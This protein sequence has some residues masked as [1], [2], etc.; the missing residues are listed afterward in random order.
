[1]KTTKTAKHTEIQE[2]KQKVAVAFYRVSTDKQDSLRQIEDVQRY[3]QAYGIALDS[4]S[5]EFKEVISG[6]SKLEDRKELKAMLAY[7][8]ATRPDYVVC[9]ELSRLARS[10]DALTIIENWTSKGICFIT[11]KENIK[12]LDADGRTNPMT[13]LLLG[14]LSAINI[15]ELETIKYRTKSG[16]NKTVQSG[17]WCG[18]APFGYNT[19]GKESDCRLVVNDSEAPIVKWMFERYSEGWGTHKIG[20]TLNRKKKF[21]KKGVLWRPES[22][23][24]ILSNSIYNGRRRWNNEELPTPEYLIVDDSLFTAVQDKIH[25]KPNIAPINKHYKHDYLLSGK[26]TCAC[27]NASIGQHRHDTYMCKSKKYSGGCKIKSVRMSWLDE[28]VSKHLFIHHQELLGD[29]TKIIARVDEL[30]NELQDLREKLS[31]EKRKQ[32]YLINNII[33]IGQQAFDSRFDASQEYTKTLQKRID[34]IQVQLNNANAF[35]SSLSEAIGVAQL[36]LSK[37]GGIGDKVA[38]T[39]ISKELLQK[40][41]EKIEVQPETIA[42]SLINGSSFNI[43][44]KSKKA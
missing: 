14:I 12:T 35:N 36:N 9:S 31:E 42:V 43:P 24:K 32:N 39:Y 13:Q 2:N 17:T 33:K 11:L 7:V 28:Q 22:V 19:I 4:K 21:T 6:A 44:R 38:K 20:A 40:V 3:C 30:Q 1:M 23:L 37:K 5:E 41:V 18:A 8:E 26:I 25:N 29:S 27:G 15:F 10:Q 16:L 34:E